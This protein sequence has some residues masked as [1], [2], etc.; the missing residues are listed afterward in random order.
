MARQGNQL[1]ALKVAKLNKPGRY[2][3]GL[4]LWLQVRSADNKSWLLRF[5]LN[6]RAHH[7]G[8]G[9]THTVSLLEARNRARE[10]RQLLL[11]GRES[12]PGETGCY[13]RFIA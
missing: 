12:P 10:A 7:M 4:G 3:D 2:A 11:E 1:T 6:G 8:L 9:P 5:M 13:S